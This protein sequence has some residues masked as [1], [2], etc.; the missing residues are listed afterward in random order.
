M[1]KANQPR[2]SEA[3][4][5]SFVLQHLQ[6]RG[7]EAAA[8]V[9]KGELRTKR[10][11]TGVS[12][13]SSRPTLIQLLVS[14][15]HIKQSYE[16]L[17]D[18]VDG[19]LEAFKAELRSVLFPFFVHCYLELIEASELTE[20]AELL[21]AR[22]QIF[23]PAARGGAPLARAATPDRHRRG[24]S[25]RRRARTTTPSSTARSSTCSAR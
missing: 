23:S 10:P 7:F 24:R 16:A 9:L 15:M 13:D 6:S 22:P 20:A 12:A 4:L 8:N 2:T 21:Q 14:T 18:W 11:A 5:D 1:S 3:A 19:S 17:R 25:L